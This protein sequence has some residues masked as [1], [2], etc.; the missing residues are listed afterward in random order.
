MVISVINILT[1]L[2][3][4][5]QVCVSTDHG[6]SNDATSIKLSNLTKSISSTRPAST[7]QF[8]NSILQ[9][10][11][12]KSLNADDDIR[13][14]G[15]EREGIFSSNT[16]D[17]N[18][19]ETVIEHDM[20]TD[21]LKDPQI[22]SKGVEEI[23]KSIIASTKETQE[24]YKD[25][26]YDSDQAIHVVKTDKS[27]REIKVHMRE[28]R[29]TSRIRNIPRFSQRSSSYDISC[30]SEQCP[31]A[32]ICYNK[33][34]ELPVNR[35]SCCLACSCDS[36]CG[37]I[38]NCCDRRENKDFMCHPTSLEES[39]SNEH[40]TVGYLMIDK[41][42][43]ASNTDC[44]EMDA[45]P[46]GSLYPVYDPA[47]NMNY[48]NAPCAE[49]HGMKDLTFWHINI[50]CRPGQN[51]NGNILNT[52]HGKESDICNIIFTPPKSM[53]RQTHVC[54][55]TL[56]SHC[57]VTGAW[58]IYTAKVEEACA[59]WFS[60][61]VDRYG[62]IR[63]ANIFCMICNGANYV[64]EDVCRDVSPSRDTGAQ[65]MTFSIN[66]RRVMDLV[67]DNAESV[68]N[69]VCGT[70]MVKHPYKVRESHII[71]NTRPCNIQTFL[72]L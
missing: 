68:R 69:G 47:N 58:K 66:Y 35:A 67:D 24:A 28:A 59:R 2:I 26:Y 1:F 56:I 30:L 17:A 54:S 45:A 18:P 32:N 33:A 22:L 55:N 37:V 3:T 49:C 65:S 19:I 70:D 20:A 48:Y 51:S 50:V 57:N 14:P 11:G 63:Y 36:D 6:R 25:D 44:K 60:P 5:D 9:R 27:G 71:T 21:F 42:L 41:C 15:K 52:I 53:D 13:I 39:R 23:F 10:T 4:A 43:D 64:P 8:L 40:V 12:V 61:V 72:E 31:Y 38:G 29:D 7:E 46:W 34:K 62:R 16:A